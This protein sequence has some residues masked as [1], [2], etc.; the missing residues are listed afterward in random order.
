MPS[1][2]EVRL[3]REGMPDV[4]LR[5]T[6]SGVHAV[7]SRWL[8]TDASA[9]SSGEAHASEHLYSVAWAPMG[10]HR[11]AIRLALLDDSLQQPLRERACP[12]MGGTLGQATVVVESLTFRRNFA[13]L[14]DTLPPVGRWRLTFPAGVTFN[15]HGVYS[16]WPS[17]ERVLNSLL[18]RQSLALGRECDDGEAAALAAKVTVVDMDLRRRHHWIGSRSAGAPRPINCVAGEVEWSIAERDDAPTR[19][20]RLLEF[21]TFSGVGAKTAWGIGVLKAQPSGS[22]VKSAASPLDNQARVPAMAPVREVCL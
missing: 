16:P 8:H 18:R 9:R 13:L 10:S 19:I 14:P 17:P 7:T 22:P 5:P 6:A 20:A 4:S 21:G 3:R 1:L 15:S 11:A 2:W 12:G